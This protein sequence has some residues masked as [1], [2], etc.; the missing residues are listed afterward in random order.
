MTS[1]RRT[2]EVA[3]ARTAYPL[4]AATL[5][6]PAVALLHRG[7]AGASVRPARHVASLH[8]ETIVPA[9][10]DD[11]FA[12]FADASRLQCL[13]PGWLHFTIV[14]PPPLT[15]RAGLEIEYRIR[16]YGVPI[17]WR[18]RIDV[19]EPGVRFVDVQLLGPYRWWHHEHRFERVPGG[20]RVVD[21]VEYVPRARWISGRL[22]RRDV[23]RIFTHR[24]QALR[25]IFFALPAGEPVGAPDGTAAS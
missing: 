24:E 20:T 19:W 3:F 13:T 11:T 5:A 15:M 4:V 10:L 2:E 25:R 8:R 17:P 22:V 16:L 12:F 21:H 14:T 18:S 7:L 23:E 9:S 1:N 6:A